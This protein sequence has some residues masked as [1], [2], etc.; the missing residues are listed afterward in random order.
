V[1]SG[2][3]V[4]IVEDDESVRNATENFKRSMRWEVLSFESADAFL[5]SGAVS[6]TR[7]LITDVTMSGMSGIEMYAHLISQG[8]VPPTIFITG[9]PNARDEAMALANGALAYLE[10]PVQTSV[11]SDWVQKLMASP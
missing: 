2:A 5:V 3:F 9:F 10:K 8:C 7:C 6:Q 1:T 4:S 11:I